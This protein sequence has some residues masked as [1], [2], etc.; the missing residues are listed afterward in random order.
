[1]VWQGRHKC[2]RNLHIAI[3]IG[4]LHLTGDTPLTI[5]LVF[6]GNRACAGNLIINARHAF[7]A[8]AKFTQRSWPNI[9]TQ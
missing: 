7:E 3:L 4:C 2:P 8:H 6:L 1:M 9:I 5:N